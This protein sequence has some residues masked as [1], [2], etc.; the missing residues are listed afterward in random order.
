MYFYLNLFEPLENSVA[1]KSNKLTIK[2]VGELLSELFVH[3]PI[4]HN[5]K[6]LDSFILQHDI[7]FDESVNTAKWKS[8]HM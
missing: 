6:N 4:K 5:E 2:V 8:K 1:V 7:E 3:K